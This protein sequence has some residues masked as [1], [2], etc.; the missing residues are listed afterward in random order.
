MTTPG[1]IAGAVGRA[2]ASDGPYLIEF[3]LSRDPA[4]TEGVNIGHWDLPK[5]AYL[6]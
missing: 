5:P 1:E 6:P 3:M 2:L 4:D